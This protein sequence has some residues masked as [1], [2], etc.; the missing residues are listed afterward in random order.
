MN[1]SAHWSKT[2]RFDQSLEIHHGIVPELVNKMP[3]KWHM[4]KHDY[5]QLDWGYPV[6]TKPYVPCCSRHGIMSLDVSST[7][8]RRLKDSGKTWWSQHWKDTHHFWSLATVRRLIR[9]TLEIFGASGAFHSR[10]GHWAMNW[11][12]INA[13]CLAVS[14]SF[15]QVPV[16]IIFYQIPYSSVR[17]KHVISD[18]KAS[19]WSGS[20]WFLCFICACPSCFL[21]FP[22]TKTSWHPVSRPE[23][24]H[25]PALLVLAPDSAERG[26][27]FLNADCKEHQR[28][29]VGI[30]LLKSLESL[31]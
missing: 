8:E 15:I 9:G 29:M 7:R 24:Y 21:F 22:G 1:S 3:F 31:E 13:T 17:K 19:S 14:S 12:I 10:L 6:F 30:R 26:D 11:S 5:Y 25:G 28:A 27:P 16:S 20:V 4:M 23:K 18:V 2:Q